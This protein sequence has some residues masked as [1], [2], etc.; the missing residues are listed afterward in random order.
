M[1]VLAIMR[2]NNFTREQYDALR[3]LVEWENE[4]P[5]G[6]I[7][8]TCA[9]DPKG[10][11]RVVDVWESQEKLETFFKTRLQPGLKKLNLELPQMDIYP[12]YNFNAFPGIETHIPRGKAKGA[13]ATR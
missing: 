8:H 3:P 9:I 5:A 11:I 6:A 1:A 4:Y 2:P 10:G 12:L 13:G 7:L